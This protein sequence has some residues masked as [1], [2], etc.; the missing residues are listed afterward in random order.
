MKK[1]N[2]ILFIL[3]VGIN[4][5]PL[6]AQNFVEN[7][8]CS[9][10][11]LDTNQT[12]IIGKLA[13]A[14]GISLNQNLPCGSGSSEDNPTWWVFRPSSSSV[15]FTIMATNCMS[16]GGAA[17]VHTTLWE[18]DFCGNIT[19]LNC[20][21]D[22]GVLTAPVSPCKTY[23]L[24]V[25]GVTE[26]I[27]D[28]VISYD[29]N[30]LLK[31]VGKP[32]ITGP[33]QIC[34]G[35]NG[36]FCASIPSMAGCRPDSW[37]WTVEPA[38]AGTIT[39]PTGSD[40]ATLKLTGVIPSDGKIKVCVEPFFKG[41]CLP[42]TQ[43]ECKE[44][45]VLEL[46]SATCD[47]VLCPESRPVVYELIQCIKTANPTM[48]SPHTPETFVIGNSFLPGT[49]TI[50]KIDYTVTGSGCKGDVN[51]KIT[52]LQNKD[53]ILPP[54]IL[55]E[56]DTA[57]VKG[58]NYSCVLASNSLKTIK[59]ETSEMDKELGAC[60][61]T[62]KF[63]VQCIKVK[64]A[65]LPKGV[66]DCTTKS[67]TLNAAA[68]GTVTFPLDVS[69]TSF[70]GKGTRVYAWSKDGITLVGETNPTLTV[71]S[72]GKYEVTLSYTY[73]VSQTI[74][75]VPVVVK[76]TCSKT[77][78]VEIDGNPL[79]A[80][81]AKA[82]VNSP[83]CATTSALF[84]A[85][86][87]DFYQ[88]SGPNNFSSTIQN[89]IL[90]NVETK[91]SGNYSVTVSNSTNCKSI[92]VVNLEV[93]NCVAT[94]DILAEANI[95]IFPNPIQNSLTVSANA[96]IQKVEISNS[97]GQVLLSQ[98]ADNQKFSINTS[99]LPNGIYFTKVYLGE[100]IFKEFKIIKQ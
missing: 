99:I 92:V 37:K 51:L 95:E 93:K 72:A 86:G 100:N 5:A 50:K 52:V 20:I 25:D 80:P 91:Q 73:E 58:E 56:G 94:E 90:T 77:T 79:S 49:T 36:Q 19:A 69:N 12:T 21:F 15:Q 60:D 18:G 76:K 39:G 4:I 22:S 70:T 47:L 53:L 33:A 66:L 6:A 44:I 14:N 48:K 64:L 54:I 1:L 3:F 85:S 71:T 16:G 17:G 34:K 62:F 40:C 83:I 65:N 24:Q 23:Y 28:M 87:G 88:W 41:T 31:Q 82:S 46:K 89:P 10:I 74:N 8:P 84:N 59:K 81:N 9:A 67:I 30:Q 43:K 7:T 42:K 78:S 35:A 55:C 26:S 2:V 57:N 96:M 32:R 27:C 68:T 38:S 75:S 29:N 97:L 13:P 61:T 63:L 98:N 45:E 11:C